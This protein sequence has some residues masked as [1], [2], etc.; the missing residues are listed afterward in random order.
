MSAYSEMI[1]ELDAERARA[2]AA[3][4][5]LDHERRQFHRAYTDMTEARERADKAEAALAESRRDAGRLWACVD[6]WDAMVIDYMDAGISGDRWKMEEVKGRLEEAR[7]A[8]KARR[9]DVLEHALG[10]GADASGGIILGEDED[11]DGSDSLAFVTVFEPM[12][13]VIVCVCHEQILLRGV[14]ETERICPKCGERWSLV[15]DGC[16]GAAW[17]HGSDVP[18]TD[19]PPR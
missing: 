10:V 6:A 18:V 13:A 9:L 15:P 5:A 8:L 16:G 14:N 4:A 12:Y 1:A 19:A 7:K 2:D 3:E 11:A 17:V